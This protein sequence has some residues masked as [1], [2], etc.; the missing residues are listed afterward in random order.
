MTYEEGLKESFKVKWKTV[1]CF[2]GEDCWC[3]MIVP[4]EKIIVDG[5]EEIT[6]VSSAALGKKEA[7]YIVNLHNKSLD[8]R[9]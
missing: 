7:E 4:E 5:D 8:D 9:I 2:A 1:T 3:R 6:I